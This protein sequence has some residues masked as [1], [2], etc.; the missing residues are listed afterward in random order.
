MNFENIPEKQ[1]SFAPFIAKNLS[2]QEQEGLLQEILS[3]EK[4]I[5]PPD[6][7]YE[8]AEIYYR[9]MLEN[10]SAIN[11][12]LRGENNKV[13]GYLLAKPLSDVY[14]E[15]AQDD[16]ELKRDEQCYYI[17]TTEILPEYAKGR[18]AL[19]FF[20]VLQGEIEE[21]HPE[22]NAISAHARVSNGLA[23]VLARKVKKS[24]MEERS[25]EKW[26]H[27]GG[28]PYAYI[29]WGLEKKQENDL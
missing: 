26:A 21:N 27:G 23:D 3:L 22:Y 13:V 29:Q 20:N 18:G 19:K 8:D 11:I 7:L 4:Q 12:F 1:P 16:P 5:F 25:I 15:L 10:P 2:E 14:E 9:E 6:W 24:L 17:E 28:E